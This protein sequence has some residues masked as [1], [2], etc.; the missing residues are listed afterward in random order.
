MVAVPSRNVW[1]RATE[2]SQSSFF[3]P[4]LLISGPALTKA[5]TKIY[6]ILP[7]QEAQMIIEVALFLSFVAI[8]AGAIVVKAYGWRQDVLYGPYI[9]QNDWNK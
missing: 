4:L 1:W 9:K 5:F 8:I 6:M 3:L 7:L 2:M